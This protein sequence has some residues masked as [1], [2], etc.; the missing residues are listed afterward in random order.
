MYITYKEDLEELL[1]YL[2]QKYGAMEIANVSEKPLKKYVDTSQTFN[3]HLQYIGVPFLIV[4]IILSILFMIPLNNLLLA[5][6]TYPT[7][8]LYC[9]LLFITFFNYLRKTREITKDFYSPLYESPIRVKKSNI[10][11]LGEKLEKRYL[12]QFLYEFDTRKEYHKLRKSENKKDVSSKQKQPKEKKKN[13]GTSK[14]K[15]PNEKRKNKGTEKEPLNTLSRKKGKGEKKDTSI[16]TEDP[17]EPSKKK[18]KGEIN[19]ENFSFFL[20]D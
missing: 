12:E 6:F 14:Q 2:K 3:K 18:I 19:P 1:L 11:S 9:T 15:Q 5:V 7:I 16:V 4:G 8:I 20:E 10:S 17:K 13:K